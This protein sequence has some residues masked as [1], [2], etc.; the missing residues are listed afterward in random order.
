M[1]GK[2][3]FAAAL[4]AVVCSLALAPKAAHAHGAMVMMNGRTFLPG[5]ILVR[6]NE[7]RL[8]YVIGGGRAIAY[9]VGVGRAGKQW[10]GES[11]IDGMYIRPAWSPPTLS[12]GTAPSEFAEH[13]CRGLAA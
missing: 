7:R 10:A 3:L 11:Y 1:K 9:P 2:A 4:A 13:R 5:T 8:Y 12:C 6:T